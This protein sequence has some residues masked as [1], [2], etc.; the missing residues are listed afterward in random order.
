MINRSKNE[1]K[2]SE[3]I[4]VCSENGNS[5]SQ[6]RLHLNG[7]KWNEK[8]KYI[9]KF[10]DDM[11]CRLRFSDDYLWM[12]WFF[13]LPHSRFWLN[14]GGLNF[15]LLHG[16]CSFSLPFSSTSY[17]YLLILLNFFS[18]LI[19]YFINITNVCMVDFFL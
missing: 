7:M 12:K 19:I 11:S 4:S 6:L 3:V 10:Y 2:K 13:F 15:R 5:D 17:S 8:Y 14:F 18:S 1:K 16:D 9:Y